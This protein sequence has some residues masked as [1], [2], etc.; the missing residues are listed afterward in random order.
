MKKIIYHQNL[1]I[2][3]NNHREIVFQ[4]STCPLC[5][6]IEEIE[7]LKVDIFDLQEQY[8]LTLESS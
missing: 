8:D 4:G 6:K 7:I 1:N 5:E 2:C 3:T